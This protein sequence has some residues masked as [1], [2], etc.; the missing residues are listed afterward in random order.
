MK[1]TWSSQSANLLLLVLLLLLSSYMALAAFLGRVLGNGHAAHYYAGLVAVSISFL[2]YFIFPRFYKRVLGFTLVLALFGVVR[3]LPAT[4]K[5]G[6][7]LGDE[8]L[9]IDLLIAAVLT[10]FYFLNRSSANAFLRRYIV[11]A[12]TP[13]QAA[14]HRREA[15][16]QFKQTFASRSNT[17]LQQLTRD[18]RLVVEAV[19]AA[20]ELLLERG[21]TPSSTT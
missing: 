15:I 18:P 5:V 14:Q 19:A 2:S 8:P 20:Q 6:L 21:A 4:I 1:L 7:A 16:E 13:A 11:P 12:P 10:A 17:S 3:F 9:G